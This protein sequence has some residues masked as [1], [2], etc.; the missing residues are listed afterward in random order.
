ME[1]P[2]FH[3]ATLHA[4]L[5]NYSELLYIEREWMVAAGQIMFSAVIP[6]I[7]TVAEE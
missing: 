5:L 7:Q 6:H 1:I 2:L 4:V 3:G